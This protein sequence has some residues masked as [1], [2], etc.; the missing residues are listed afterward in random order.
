MHSSIIASQSNQLQKNVGD[1]YLKL[2]LERQTVAILSMQYAQEV[3]VVPMGRITPI[4]RMPFCV[5][6]LLNQRN[7][8]LWVVDLA[9]LLGL[10][11]VDANLQ[12][13]NV[14]IIR[15]G[16]VPLGLLV[17]EVKG[18]MRFT[19]DRI[20]SPIGNVSS[21]L[22]PYLQGCILEPMQLLLVLD[23]ETIVSSP[24]LHSK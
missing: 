7:K 1:T 14:A 19:R 21:G 6:G 15:A 22:T 10:E 8:L 2:Q 20:Q 16:Q 17:Q 5:R 9:H 3:V 12:Q 4:P 11:P 23:A 24:I 18:V 13:Y